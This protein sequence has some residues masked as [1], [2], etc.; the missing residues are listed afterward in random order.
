MKRFGAAKILLLVTIIML[1]L[2]IVL[3]TVSLFH[4]TGEGTQK[5]TVIDSSFRLY[6]NETFRQG[7]GALQGGE[8]VSVTVESATAFMKNFS[9][10]TSNAT[11]YSNLTNKNITTSFVAEAHYYEVIF[12]NTRTTGWVHLQAT[13][14]KTQVLYPFFWLNASSKVMFLLS[15]AGA[16]LVCLKTAL[17]NYRGKTDENSKSAILDKSFRNRLLVLLLFSLIVWLFV[18]ALNSSPL[19]TFNNWYTDHARDSYV[20]SLFVK[21]GFSVFN[22]PLGALSSQDSSRYMFVTWPEMPHLYPLGSIMV[23]LPFGALLQSGFD[24]HFGLQT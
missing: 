23:F 2:S 10:A 24:P 22:H 14:E 6:Q 13:I 8:T 21:D 19:A 3:S 4:V 1:V 18:L 12:S 20:S 11:I 17:S 16:V 9:I 5:A 7:L 15:A